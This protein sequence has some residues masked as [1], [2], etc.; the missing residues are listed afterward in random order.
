VP[1]WDPGADVSG[2][3]IIASDGRGATPADAR[4]REPIFPL[5]LARICLDARQQAYAHVAELK[6]A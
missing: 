2:E 4:L 3:T 5:H 1:P 6:D